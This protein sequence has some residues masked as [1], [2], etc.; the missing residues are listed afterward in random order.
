MN[1]LST[2]NILVSVVLPVYNGSSYLDKSIESILNQSFTQ[3]EL[4]IVNDGS[5]DNSIEVIKHFAQKDQR[6][7]YFE[8]KENRGISKAYN[9]AI[10]S[11]I[12][13][14]IA[15]QEQD[16]ISLTNRLQKQVLVLLTYDVAFV[17]SKVG[18]IN[19]FGQGYKDWPDDIN[20]DIEI[21]VPRKDLFE[22]IIKYQTIFP[23][24]STMIDKQR[25]LSED[26]IFD[27]SFKSSGQDWDF[28]LRLVQ[29]YKTCR[30]KEKLLLMHRFENHDSSTSNKPRIFLD[31]RRVLRK[32]LKLRFRYFLSDATL[33]LKAWSHELWLE[34]RHFRGISGLRK[35]ML[36]LL[37][38][39]LNVEAWL[40]FLRVTKLITSRVTRIFLIRLL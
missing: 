8:H 15:F 34:A 23:N 28:H 11:C 10:G 20:D 22:R 5:I 13:R 19:E 37:L 1:L 40:S 38:W 36:S 39:P 7:K 18:W 24:A 2:R 3:F 16:D 33:I 27:E 29:K 17:T 30:M 25:I 9:T 35:G 6:V 14:Y 4:V 31:N 26:L 21:F 32:H 12:G